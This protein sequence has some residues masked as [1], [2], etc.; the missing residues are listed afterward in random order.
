MSIT[1]IEIIIKPLREVD[2][3]RLLRMNTQWNQTAEDWQRFISLAPDGCFKAVLKKDKVTHIT[4][5]SV[6]AIEYDN[7]NIGIDEKKQMKMAWI[8][9]LYVDN[10]Y[11]KQGIGVRLLKH[12]ISYLKNKNIGIIKLDAT[13]LGHKLYIQN[14][15]NVE[16]RL[17][18]IS[19][20]K[21]D[22]VLPKLD[23][24]IQ[25]PIKITRITSEDIING[26]LDEIY[27]YDV[28]KTKLARRNILEKLIQDNLK[29]IFV[30]KNKSNIVGYII[31]RTGRQA[32]QIGPLIANNQNIALLLLNSVIKISDFS[33]CILAVYDE[34]KNFIEILKKMGGKTERKYIRM[35]YGNSNNDYFVDF[36]WCIS[37]AE[38]G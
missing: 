36:E 34:H 25:G 22:F 9:M 26:L 27:D 15:F 31:G 16:R 6:S 19:V 4:V 5:G 32:F 38:K 3:P 2:I 30:A 8:G 24:N 33:S 23:P 29:H 13:P 12:A 17:S 21:N 11:R 18:L 7:C 28:R 1:R 37:G 20:T 35:Y 10:E 14:G